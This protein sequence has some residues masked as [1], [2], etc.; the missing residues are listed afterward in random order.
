TKNKV[1][2]ISKLFCNWGGGESLHC[3]NFNDLLF[4]KYFC[5]IFAILHRLNKSCVLTLCKKKMNDV[6]PLE[7]C[8][9][10]LQENFE[11]QKIFARENPFIFRTEFNNIDCST[12][13][14][15]KKKTSKKGFASGFLLNQQKKTT[16]KSKKFI[17]KNDGQNK[18]NTLDL[19][20]EP[21]N[22]IFFKISCTNFIILHIKKKSP[23]ICQIKE[24]QKLLE[25]SPGMYKKKLF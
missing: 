12:R 9:E 10:F 17:N 22:G 11:R 7:D 8:S 24:A 2:S 25:K 1:F 3:N 13:H 20:K 18:R 5:K 14:R 6:P 16:S 15:N 23:K 21:N 19:P 4:E